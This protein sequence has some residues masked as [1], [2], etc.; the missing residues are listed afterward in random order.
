ME[1]IIKNYTHNGIAFFMFPVANINSQGQVINPKFSKELL[2]AAYEGE[3]WEEVRTDRDRRISAT[4]WTQ[5][6][7]AP[8]TA[9]QKAAFADYRQTLRDIPQTYSDP[10]LVE[11]PAVPT[12]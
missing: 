2:I 10:D 6:P 7:D 11:W 8:L 9:E 3:R 4:D 1:K 5:M 12:V